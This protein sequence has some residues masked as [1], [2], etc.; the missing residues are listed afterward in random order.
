MAVGG[1][2]SVIPAD[3]I[4]L[5]VKILA[6]RV[7]PIF[8]AMAAPLAYSTE[9]VAYDARKITFARPPRNDSAS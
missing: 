3:S 9:R 2:A 8:A 7:L 5:E 1:E 4:A 6:N